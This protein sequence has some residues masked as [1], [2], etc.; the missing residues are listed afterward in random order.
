MAKPGARMT[1]RRRASRTRRK[2]ARY[3]T[4][5]PPDLKRPTTV[6][7]IVAAVKRESS[8]QLRLAVLIMLLVLIGTLGLSIGYLIA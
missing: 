4:A 3:L 6:E 2:P 7:A 8:D 1:A 5:V